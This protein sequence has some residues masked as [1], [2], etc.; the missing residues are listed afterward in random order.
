M[1][2][3]EIIKELRINKGLTQERLGQL[4]NLAESTISLYESNKRSPDYE[5]LKKIADFF[6]VTTD[7]L[8]GRTNKKKLANINNSTI[9]SNSLEQDYFLDDLLKRVP[10]LTD[11]EKESL[12]A[13][14]DFAIKLIEK[15]RKE[16]AQGKNK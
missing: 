8:L 11:K 9:K 3:G 13:H 4:I 1:E 15:E 6:E 14:L 2:L 16:R 12:E 10:D 5:T 7:Y